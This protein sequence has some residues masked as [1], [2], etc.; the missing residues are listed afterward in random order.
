MLIGSCSNVPTCCQWIAFDG[1]FAEIFIEYPRQDSPSLTLQIPQPLESSLENYM[2][3]SNPKPSSPLTFDLPESL[4][5]RMEACRKAQGFPSASAIVRA[6]I[7]GFDFERCQ[8]ARDPHRQ[9]SVRVETADRQRMR[10]IS[11]KKDASVGELLRQALE[12]LLSKQ[13]KKKR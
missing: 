4:I 13:P 11:K 7:E 10:K 5:A 8:P 3:K 6:A 2:A 9:I 12:A 1:F